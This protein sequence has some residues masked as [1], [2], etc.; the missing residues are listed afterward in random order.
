M[1]KAAAKFRLEFSVD[2]DV[3]FQQTVTQNEF[4]IRHSVISVTVM[5]AKTE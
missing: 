5:S 2:R 3:T 1:R 4:A